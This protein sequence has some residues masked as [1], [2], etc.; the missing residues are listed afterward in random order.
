MK[1][2]QLIMLLK[3]NCDL[4][5]EVFIASD[6]EGNQISIADNICPI[7]KSECVNWELMYPEDTELKHGAVVIF[8]LY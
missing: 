7:A 6:E 1:V 2:K 5:S 8:P 4:E 3:N